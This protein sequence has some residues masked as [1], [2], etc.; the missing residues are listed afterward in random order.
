[1]IFAEDDPHKHLKEL[2]VVCVSMKS[3]EVTKDQIK[4][5]AFPLFLKNSIKD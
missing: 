2:H 4:L 3:T 5:R 1:M